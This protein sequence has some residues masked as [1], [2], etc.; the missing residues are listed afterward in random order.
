MDQVNHP[1]SATIHSLLLKT[2]GGLG[3]GQEIQTTNRT[4]SELNF[5]LFSPNDKEEL[6]MYAE[7]PCVSSPLSQ[8]RLSIQFTA[9]DSCPVGF[10]KHVDETTMCECICD[11]KLKPYVTKCNAST[12]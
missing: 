7:G 8:R 9:C 10:K 12:E 6:I 2:G 3:A 4:C 1:V 5:N 11:S